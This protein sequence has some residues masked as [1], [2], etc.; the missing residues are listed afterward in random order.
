VLGH[1][2]AF[3]PPEFPR[4]LWKKGSGRPERPCLEESTLLA[5]VGAPPL[6][7]AAVTGR[8]RYVPTSLVVPRYYVKGDL[9]PVGKFDDDNSVAQ[10]DQAAERRS[11]PCAYLPMLSASVQSFDF[12]SASV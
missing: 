2:R 1:Q 12:M 10:G 11:A 3:L 6:V 7:C 8:T 5:R 9:C 4:N